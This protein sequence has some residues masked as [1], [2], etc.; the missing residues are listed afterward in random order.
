MDFKSHSLEKQYKCI[1]LLQEA[2]L[3][4]YRPSNSF[5][6]IL[7]IKLFYKENTRKTCFSQRKSFGLTAWDPVVAEV[8]WS[9]HMNEG[10][11]SLIR[12]VPL[13]TIFFFLFLFYFLLLFTVGRNDLSSKI[14]V[15]FLCGNF[16]YFRSIPTVTQH[17]ELP[18]KKKNHVYCLKL[19]K[20]EKDVL[21]GVLSS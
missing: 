21:D 8:Y 17:I 3:L 12:L 14:L 6:A 11:E 10:M 9:T 2:F 18:K 19:I 20:S 16:R 13:K 7:C 15:S 5:L 4:E 1:H